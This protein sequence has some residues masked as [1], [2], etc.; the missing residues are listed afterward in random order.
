MRQCVEH[1]RSDVGQ[2]VIAQRE[3]TEVGE[4]REDSGSQ[5]RDLIV[6]QVEHGDDRETAESGH[7]DAPDGVARQPQ[8]AD[9][10]RRQTVGRQS[11]DEVLGHV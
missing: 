6:A 10:D 3:R 2:S 4:R 8:P 9:A 5:V 1:L 7:R 11:H